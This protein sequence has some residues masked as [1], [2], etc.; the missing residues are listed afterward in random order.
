MPEFWLAFGKKSHR[1]HQSLKAIRGIYFFSFGVYFWVWEL[2]VIKGL[3]EG[4]FILPLILTNAF[5]QPIQEPASTP[6]KH[7]HSLMVPADKRLATRILTWHRQ[8]KARF[9]FEFLSVHSNNGSRLYNL[10]DE[11]YCLL[12]LAQT[13]LNKSNTMEFFLMF[14]NF[15]LAWSAYLLVPGESVLLY[16]KIYGAT[17]VNIWKA[18]FLSFPQWRLHLH[19]WW[20]NHY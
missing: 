5:L 15:L 1:S 19:L 18:W 12:N 13:R 7:C 9:L 3:K 6:R 2:Y 11:M 4:E 16:L 10:W 8:N 14:S 20:S 17:C